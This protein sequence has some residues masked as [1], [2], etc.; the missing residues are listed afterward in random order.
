[1]LQPLSCHSHQ[2]N[3][4]QGERP[5]GFHDPQVV[6]DQ[7][8]VTQ[9]YYMTDKIQLNPIIVW[10]NMHFVS[11]MHI[12]YEYTYKLEIT[13]IA[14]NV[15]PYR[16]INEHLEGIANVNASQMSAEELEFHYFK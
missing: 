7:E 13:E 10:W 15:L 9:Y 5:S 2:H 11:Y 8:W 16:H 14:C 3:R 6:H 12:V 1:M 4:A